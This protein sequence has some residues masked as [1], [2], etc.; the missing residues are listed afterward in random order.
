[1]N[2]IIRGRQSLPECSA[3]TF[4]RGKLWIRTGINTSAGKVQT[5]SLCFEFLSLLIIAVVGSVVG[6]LKSRTSNDNPAGALPS[7]H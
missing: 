7:G 1:M 3:D 6:G 4:K 5:P 2:I